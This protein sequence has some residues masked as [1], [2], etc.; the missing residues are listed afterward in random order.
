MILLSRVRTG[1]RGLCA[2]GRKQWSAYSAFSTLN[3]KYSDSMRRRPL[4]F[5]RD[6]LAGLELQISALFISYWPLSLVS[7]SLRLADAVCGWQRS[8]MKLYSR[9][10]NYIGIL[11]T[12]NWKIQNVNLYR[13]Y[14]CKLN[15]RFQS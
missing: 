6:K 4:R 5:H 1:R 11:C 14:N 2:V 10:N 12:D 7:C 3:F 13:R 15:F 9:F 8:N